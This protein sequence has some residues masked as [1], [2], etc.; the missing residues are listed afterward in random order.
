MVEGSRYRLPK[1]HSVFRIIPGNSMPS[2][3]PAPNQTSVTG[4]PL[5]RSPPHDRDSNL[6]SLTGTA[7]VG[8]RLPVTPA[9]RPNSI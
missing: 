9:A 4:Q 5:Q 2:S 6:H 3:G 1:T 7:D 8:M